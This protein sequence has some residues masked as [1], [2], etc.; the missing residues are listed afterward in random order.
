MIEIVCG[1]CKGSGKLQ[2]SYCKGEGGSYKILYRGKDYGLDNNE[3]LHLQPH[4]KAVFVNCEYCEG[5]EV[6]C[7]CIK[8]DDLVKIEESV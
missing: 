6:N 1:F 2:C 5:G 4:S 8:K 7:D 3:Q